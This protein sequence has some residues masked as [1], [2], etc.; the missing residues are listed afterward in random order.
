MAIF[1]L[2]AGVDNFTGNAGE[3]NTF[4][5]TASTL[6]STD[7]VTGGATCSFI[8]ILAHQSRHDHRGPVRRCHQCRTAHPPQRHQFVTLTN[9]LAAGTSLASGFFNVIGGTGADII[10]GSAIN[11]GIRLTITAA[12]GADTITGGTGDDILDGGA[13]ADVMFGGA[14][15]DSYYVDHDSDLVAENANEGSDTVYAS[16]DYNLTADVETLVL[17]GS[18]EQGYGN[19]LANALYGNSGNN[20]LNGQADA[21]AMY[22]GAGNDAYF[23]DNSGDVVVENANEGI[24][25]V[26]ATVDYM[27]TPNVEDL[28]LLGGPD[29]QGYGNELANKIYGND[30]NNLLNGG[31]GADAMIGGDGNDAYFVDDAGDQ[32]SE[33][34]NEGTDTVYSTADFGLTENLEDLVLLGS[35]EQGYGN[36]QNNT[37]YGNDGN[38]LLNGGLGAERHAGWSSATMS[39]SWTMAGDQVAETANQGNDT[40]YSTADFGLTVNIEKTDSPSTALD[41]QGYGTSGANAIYGNIGNKSFSAASA[42]ADAIRADA[43]N[44]IIQINRQRVP[45]H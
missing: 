42:V 32:V 44:D 18:A 15:N 41:L 37:I 30:F 7:T 34:A 33:D 21:D 23:V 19:A 1:T 2:A 10:D 39:T 17:Q 3:D 16:V 25:T 8:D 36:T 29:Q 13:G 4:Q 38:N 45:A 35:A 11:N 6:Q 43:G 31:A 24:D 14:G 40:V 9:G 5:V 27:L 20:L 26:Y 28:V 12:G 22:G